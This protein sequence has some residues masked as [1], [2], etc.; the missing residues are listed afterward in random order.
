MVRS[1]TLSVI[2]V[3]GMLFDVYCFSLSPVYQWL[4]HAGA[5]ALLIVFI[6]FWFIFGEC[7][8]FLPHGY[9]YNK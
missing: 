2:V 4:E 1:E 6:T 9:N 7:L 8:H 5:R 3:K